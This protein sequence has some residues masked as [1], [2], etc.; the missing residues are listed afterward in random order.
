MNYTKLATAAATGAI[1][2]NAAFPI[3][4]ATTT[5]TISGNGAGA[6]SE[7]EYE[8]ET[9]TTVVQNNVSNI[10]NHVDVDADT[11]SNEAEENTG[12][13]VMIETGDATAEV[14]L[15]NQVNS[16]QAQVN[17]CG[18]CAGDVTVEIKDNGAD[19][20]NEVELEQETETTLH[21][22]NMAN[23]RNDVDADAKTGKN[24]AE[25]NTN[26][27]IKIDTGDATVKV[28]THNTANM[29]SAVI[30]GEG[31]GGSV[32]LLISGNGA[33]SENEIELELEKETALYQNNLTMISN[34]IDADAYTGKNEAEEN[35]GGLVE[36]ETGNAWAEVMVDNAA[37]FNVAELGCCALDEIS[38]KIANNGA[39]SENEIEA[40]FEDEAEVFQG[41]K[42]R[43][44]FKNCLAADVKTGDNEVED[45]TVASG[46][47]P[48]I[49]TGDATA[50]VAVS[51]E[52]AYNFLGDLEA[53][54]IEM[55]EFDFG[56]NL[57]FDF[58]F[59]D[60]LAWFQAQA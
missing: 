33:D 14:V 60:F 31:D 51:N 20:E 54:E 3:F 42:S 44:D 17:T 45:S 1:L 52:G 32:S 10:T 26:G 2:L 43:T 35:T 5:L 13:D 7:V 22:N 28:M 39:D 9:S 58:D 30:G 41:D 38:A 8:N 16:N 24:E 37:G 15:T 34:R 46:D 59:A 48:S 47:D 29:N 56:F 49:D 12:G 23:I 27:D 6:E 18:D 19:S 11:G 50:K 55:P 53:L 36:I 25:E 57:S 40:E 21:Q 4:A